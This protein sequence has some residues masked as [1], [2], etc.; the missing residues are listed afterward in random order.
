MSRALATPLLLR[1]FS[2]LVPSSVDFRSAI[3]VPLVSAAFSLPLFVELSG[4]VGLFKS[5][6]ASLLAGVSSSFPVGAELPNILLNSPPLPEKLRRLLP[7]RLID[8]GPLGSVDAS[9][10]SVSLSDKDNF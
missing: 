10:C 7:A 4:S 1:F 8:F 3:G 2:V 9:T 5:F 6:D